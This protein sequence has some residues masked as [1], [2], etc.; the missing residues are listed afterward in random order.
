M[1]KIS[2]IMLMFIAA[3]TLTFVS[4]S[5]NDVPSVPVTPEQPDPEPAPQPEPQKARYTVLVYRK[6]YTPS[7]APN[8]TN[9]Y[10]VPASLMSMSVPVLRAYSLTA[11]AASMTGSR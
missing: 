11:M 8:S 10:S 4:C 9:Q 1:K 6:K 3:M 5:Q 2:Q 7:T